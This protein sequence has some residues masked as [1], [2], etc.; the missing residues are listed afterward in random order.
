MFRIYQKYL[1]KKFLF[2]FINISIIF[3]SL[4]MILGILEEISFFKNLENN[5]LYPFFL[6]L[7]NAP[8]TLFEIFPFIFLLTVQFLIYELFKKEE[9]NL[10]KKNGLDNLKIIRILF[11]LSIFIGV[12]NVL[13]YYNVASKLKF[14]YSNIKNGLSDD[15][16][17]LAMVNESGLWIKDEINDSIL[18]IKSAY[19]DKNFLSKVIINEFNSNFDLRRTIQ[20]NKIDIKEKI[21]IIYNPTITKENINEKSDEFIVLETNFDEDKINNLFS[22]VTTLDLIR[23]FDLKKE[24]ENLGYSSDEITIHLLK[25][26]TTPLFYGVL[27]IL[28]AIIMFHFTRDKSLIFHIVIGIF[29][30][31]MIYY[32]NFIFN[33]LGNTGKIPIILSIFFPL[34][35]VS[36]ISII[37]LINV[38]EK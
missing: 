20:S 7:L 1:I 21:W 14:Q 26:F 8:I 5:I 29:M 22:N 4:S 38:N 37:G 27:T 12:F 9:L 17:Y 2:K 28:S 34:F 10:L 13:V 24:F 25:L 32:M 3:F 6:T 36:I 16:K 30:S 15:N 35:I 31:V 19:V 18:I 33:S 23:L 11:F